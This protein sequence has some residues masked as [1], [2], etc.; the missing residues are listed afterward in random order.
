MPVRV[1]EVF[2]DVGVE[3][4]VALRH[5]DRFAK[6]YAIAAEALL[7]L[8]EHLVEAGN[9]GY[10]GGGEAA[11]SRRSRATAIRAP[12][13]K[14][15]MQTEQEKA[16][17][18]RITSASATRQRRDA[19]RE[20]SYRSRASAEAR[21]LP[22]RKIDPAAHTTGTVR[23]RALQRARRIG[24]HF[25]LRA[26]ATSLRAI[27]ASSSARCARGVSRLASS[28][29][30]RPT[31]AAPSASARRLCRASRRTRSAAARETRASDSRP[32][33]TRPRDCAR[34]R[35]ARGVRRA[36]RS[37]AAGPASARR[38]CRRE[39]PPAVDRQLPLQLFEQPHRDERHSAPDDRREG[40]A[41][42]SR[43]RAS[44]SSI[45]TDVRP[46]SLV[47]SMRTPASASTNSA[48]ASSHIDTS[49]SRASA[50]T[51]PDDHGDAAP[52]DAG[53]LRGNRRER[54][55]EILLVIE[56]DRRDGRRD[57]AA[58]MF[59]ESRRPPRPTSST[60]NVDARAPEQLERDRRRHFE[61]RRRRF[62]RSIREQLV[63]EPRASLRSARRAR[64]WRPARR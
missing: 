25:D 53:F 10:L 48:P 22:T 59:V 57:R 9:V 56:I 28:P 23:P 13:K 58:T 49:T 50:A 3:L 4:H 39:S 47:D 38:E 15:I 21:G 51:R 18:R 33:P 12:L 14:L 64:L 5:L 29:S 26:R 61:E 60:A 31:G 1:A 36:L 52:D 20:R 63:D 43:S 62:E 41:A 30:S 55:A 8:R 54:V 7:H 19:L 34:R 40:P 35:A 17:F 42:S 6:R 37:S 11:A 45:R 2:D 32:A 24:L 16:G 44:A 46:S 27:A